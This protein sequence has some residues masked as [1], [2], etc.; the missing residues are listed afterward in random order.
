MREHEL[1]GEQRGSG[2]GGGTRGLEETVGNIISEK[3]LLGLSKPDLTSKHLLVCW[4]P[5]HLLL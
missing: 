5:G 4:N 3:A 1:F 2:R